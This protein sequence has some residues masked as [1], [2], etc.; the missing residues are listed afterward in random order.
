MFMFRNPNVVT[1]RQ[2]ID[3]PYN[4]TQIDGKWIPARPL[5]YYGLCL[6][7]RFKLAWRVF[8]AKD[9]VLSWKDK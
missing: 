3:A 6:F 8:T 1:P 4:E 5:G 2:L 7:R 9:D